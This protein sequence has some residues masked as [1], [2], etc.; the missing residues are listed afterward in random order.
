MRKTEHTPARNRTDSAYIGN[1]S[2]M[3]YPK[4]AYSVASALPKQAKQAGGAM[5]RLIEPAGAPAFPRFPRRKEDLPE[6]P[7]V[8]ESDRIV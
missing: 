8:D 3:S 7:K 4:T 1:K 2:Y 6:P 5:L